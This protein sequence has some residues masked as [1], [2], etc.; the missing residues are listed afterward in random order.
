M[1]WLGTNKR[2][3]SV[4]RVSARAVLNGILAISILGSSHYGWADTEER[5]EG[6]YFTAEEITAAYS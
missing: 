1:N 4:R 2:R 6:W 5:Y 3:I